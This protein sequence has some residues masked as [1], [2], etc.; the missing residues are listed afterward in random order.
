VFARLLN[1]IV[2]VLA[3]VGLGPSYI[4]LLRVRGRR[5]GKV[6]ST[7]V[8]LLEFRGR[9]YLVGGRGHTH[10]SRNAAAVGVVELV[11]G[12]Q[13]RRYHV[14]PVTDDARL[15]ILKAYLEAYANTVQRFFSVRAGSPPDSFRAIADRHPVFEL[16]I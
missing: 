13:S 1:K 2:G 3:R 5:T 9:Y 6:F 4:R 15:E 14:V 7:P 11:R 16:K 10:W 8:N 12:R